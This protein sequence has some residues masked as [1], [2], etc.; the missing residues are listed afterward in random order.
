[1]FYATSDGHLLEPNYSILELQVPAQIKS[2][3]D[4]ELVDLITTSSQT[5]MLISL[6]VSLG[7][8]FFMQMSMDPTWSLY[9]MLQVES[10]LISIGKE[11]NLFIP[12]NSYTLF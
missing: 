10:N 12:A 5:T 1:M 2:E 11:E 3:E 7:L 6:I 4:A 9:L 8:M